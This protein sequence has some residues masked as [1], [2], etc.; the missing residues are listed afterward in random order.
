MVS[1]SIVKLPCKV[2]QK[3][4]LQLVAVVMLLAQLHVCSTAFH[5][6]DGQICHEAHETGTALASHAPDHQHKREC[7]LRP[8]HEQAP[9]LTANGG[10][11]DLP[12][13]ACIL[14]SNPIVP[15]MRVVDREAVS[16]WLIE[17]SPPTGPPLL[18]LS[19]APPSILQPA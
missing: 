4:T 9:E 3:L 6:V 8:C 15:R 14:A 16:S 17:S 1:K 12:V 18:R 7:E 13:E 10:M 2:A 11:R 19:R 5:H